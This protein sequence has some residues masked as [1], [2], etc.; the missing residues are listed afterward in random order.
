MSEGFPNALCEAMLCGCIPIVSAV[1]AM[2]MIVGDTGF[3]L[4]QKEVTQLKK[5][6]D[7]VLHLENTEALILKCRQRIIENFPIEK[8]RQELISAVQEFS[9]ND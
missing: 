8:R 3:V 2:P 9:K 7:S 6:I 4:R 1:G 5:L